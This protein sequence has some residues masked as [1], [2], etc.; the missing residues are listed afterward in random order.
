MSPGR[1]ST[2]SLFSPIPLLIAMTSLIPFTDAAPLS[3]SSPTLLD[4]RSNAKSI[5]PS[6]ALILILIICVPSAAWIL[7]G[8]I[9]AH[10][11][12]FLR[13]EGRNKISAVQE[14]DVSVL[15]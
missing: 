2:T 10:Q 11:G 5:S 3:A 6:G 14:S 7:Y 13:R 9:T 15:W 4:D 12:E 8:V 1:D